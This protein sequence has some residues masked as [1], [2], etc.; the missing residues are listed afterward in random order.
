MGFTEYLVALIL[1]ALI[2]SILAVFFWRR[3]PAPG[4]VAMSIL[5]GMTMIF[6]LGYII[7][8]NAGTLSGF[9]LANSIEYIGIVGVPV[10]WFIFTIQYI[11][12]ENWLVRHWYVL[13]IIPAI[14][15]ILVWT[16]F[17]HGW[18]W[19]DAFLEPF[20]EFTVQLK[21]YGFWFWIHTLYSYALLIS[22]LVIIGKR[23]FYPGNIYRKQIIVLLVSVILPLIWNIIYIFR[24]A[25][26]YHIDMTPTAFM[27]SGVIIALGL[28]RYQ[29]LKIVPI[30]RKNVVENMEDGVIV[31]DRENR[32]L[33]VNRA[34]ENII[35]YPVRQLIGKPVGLSLTRHPDLL[36]QIQEN[37]G[38][39]HAEI[40][41]ESD[42]RRC[43]YELSL[44][45]LFDRYENVTGRVATLHDLT[46][47]KR[48]E[49]SLKEYANRITRVQ[50]EERKRIAYELHDDTVQYLS[51]LKLQIDSILGS[52][53]IRSPEVLDKLQYLEKDAGRAMDDVRR[54][55]HELRP[56]VL[57]HL[58]LLAALEQIVEDTNKLK[59]IKVK[60]N[61]EGQE[62]ELSDE[63]KLG[64]FR[65]AQEAL[66]NVRK[67]AR[68]GTAT[69]N[70]QF[71]EGYLGMEIVDNGAGFD[72]KEALTRS[73]SK[74]SLGLMSMQER[75]KL[76]GA[77]LKI[78]SEPGKGTKVTVE[79]RV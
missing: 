72:I 19:Y 67:H 48:M 64:L 16:N 38:G 77:D 12:Q 2:S 47:R 21:T 79:I 52:G 42:N 76:I 22:G 51:I 69:V 1:S 18:M 45:P 27:V 5:T 26:T 11:G 66:N 24:A 37:T 13:L 32:I 25:P 4:A 57:D 41:I 35:G 33:D 15:L 65:I 46:E 43:T 29:I 40:A 28:F 71:D 17:L 20:G 34:A 3:R 23:L 58:G 36:R 6:A 74:G 30:A 49:Q 63:V 73:G 70:L 75:A 14:T 39:S 68:T 50:E 9:R 78:I 56:G 44:I 59:Q 61:V 62:P 54:Y 55:S 60:L 53:K 8:V 7:E 31:L 10:S